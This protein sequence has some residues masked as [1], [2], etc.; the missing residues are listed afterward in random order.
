M[1]VKELMETFDTYA[2][3]FGE[4]FTSLPIVMTGYNIDSERQYNI[5]VT[6]YTFNLDEDTFRLW[7]R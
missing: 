5:P 6:D 7:D 3:I 4:K 1:T 2:A